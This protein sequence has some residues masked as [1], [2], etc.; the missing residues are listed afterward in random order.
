[1]AEQENKNRKRQADKS[2]KGDFGKWIVI[3]FLFLFELLIYTGTRLECTSTEFSISDARAEQ[4]R[5]ES[6]R[7]ELLLEKERLGSPERISRIARTRLD[8]VVPD[9]NQVVY[10]ENWD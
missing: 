2:R 7:A 5:L 8:L 6:Y 3:L 1:M 9:H 4:Q 10:L